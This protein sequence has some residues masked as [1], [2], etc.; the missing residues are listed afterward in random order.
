MNTEQ[1]LRKY[2]FT[3]MGIAGLVMAYAVFRIATCP[4][5]TNQDFCQLGGFAFWAFYGFPALFLGLISLG[6]TKLTHSKIALNLML[7]ILVLCTVRM[8]AVLFGV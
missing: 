6:L 1:I 7:A 3:F 8:V 4:V 5:G 2:S